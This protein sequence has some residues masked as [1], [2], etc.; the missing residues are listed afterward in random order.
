[1]EILLRRNG[2]V[3]LLILICISMKPLA[4]N[5]IVNDLLFPIVILIV[6][7]ILTIAGVI[8]LLIQAVFVVFVFAVLVA[9]I[10]F[11]IR[12]TYN[13][14]YDSEFIYLKGILDSHKISLS[15]VK[16]V[17]VDKEGMRVIGVTSWKYLIEFDTRV[18]VRPQMV[19]QTAGTTSVNDFVEVAKLVNPDLKFEA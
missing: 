13:V 18:K 14:F 6:L 4:P 10:G 11:G 1:M 16:R 3:L 7:S 12:D 2:Y 9:W 17:K 15:S 5:N 8:F 19:H